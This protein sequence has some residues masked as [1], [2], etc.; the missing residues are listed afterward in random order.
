MP[1]D[2]RSW[3]TWTQQDLYA[4]KNHAATESY[5]PS[6]YS[7]HQ[8]T[9]PSGKR[10]E[11]SAG[12]FP[13]HPR[14]TEAP[15]AIRDKLNTRQR[16]RAGRLVRV[17]SSSFASGN[18]LL[19]VRK[20]GTSTQGHRACTHAQVPGGSTRLPCLL[21]ISLGPRNRVGQAG[22]VPEQSPE[23]GETLES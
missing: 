18:L 6:V 9:G 20:P 12:H 1:G 3:S 4:S 5:K 19:D 8:I 22:C 16:Q 11:L 21:G 2:R 7:L 14:H 15:E 13:I 17:T 23:P 10:P